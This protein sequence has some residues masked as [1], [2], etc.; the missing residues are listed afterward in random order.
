MPLPSYQKL[1]L[2]TLQLLADGAPCAAREINEQLAARLGLT[3]EQRRERLAGGNLVLIDRASWA[4]TYMKQAG[5]IEYPQRG[6]SRIT[7]R[8]REAIRKAPNGIDLKY[9]R[10]FPE[11]REFQQRPGAAASPT[12][13]VLDASSSAKSADA[14][15]GD[16]MEAGYLRLRASVES[17]LLARVMAGS[18][19]FFENLVIHLLV[20]L[21]YGGSMAEAET[22]GRAGDGGIDGVVKQDR[23][24]LDS[25]YVQAKRWSAP[26]GRPV[27]QAFV[28]ALHGVNARRGIL[29]TTSTFT[30]EA[31]EY[32]ANVGLKVVLVDG[33]A[34]AT[35]MFDAGLGVTT[36]STYVVKQLDSDFFEDEAAPAAGVGSGGAPP[37]VLDKNTKPFSI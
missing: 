15:P 21:G 12:S 37:R 3:A 33:A 10:Q 20:A 8:G 23:L 5:L 1:M 6:Y 19:E 32:A 11:F 30:R 24:G 14:T 9:L 28:G 27:V 13:P 22:V 17:E 4:R 2:P 34:L 26:V 25:I 35:F 18:P 36:A 16:L 29:F 7:S 31:T